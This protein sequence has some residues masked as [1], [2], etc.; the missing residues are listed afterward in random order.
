MLVCELI[1]E[2]S[3]WDRQTTSSGVLTEGNGVV[4]VVD[5][6]VTVLG[7]LAEVVSITEF[8]T[9]VVSSTDGIA[10]PVTSSEEEVVGKSEG[11]GEVWEAGQDHLDDGDVDRDGNEGEL[12]DSVDELSVSSESA[13]E[14]GAFSTSASGT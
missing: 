12:D 3:H 6:D 14:L 1:S 10:D 5:D 8:K 4:E 2:R 11:D 9:E 13:V 7:S